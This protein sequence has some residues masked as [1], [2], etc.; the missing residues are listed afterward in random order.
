[1]TLESLKEDYKKTFSEPRLSGKFLPENL[2]KEFFK[3]IDVSTTL[4][5]FIEAIGSINKD[6]DERHIIQRILAWNNETPVDEN[7]NKLV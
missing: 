6:V 1:M 2:Q 3:K 7:G 4:D 5:E